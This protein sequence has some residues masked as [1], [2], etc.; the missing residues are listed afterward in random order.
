MSK[1]ILDVL[2]DQKK[3]E[4][5][6]V[7][8]TVQEVEN[9]LKNEGVRKVNTKDIK[10]LGN[11]FQEA[12]SNGSEAIDENKLASVGGGFSLKKAALAA[13]TIGTVVAGGYFADK[14]LNEGKGM[15]ALKSGAD[16]AKGQVN[17]WFSGLNKKPNLEMGSTEAFE[18]P[19]PEYN[20][21]GVHM[22]LND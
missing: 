20:D 14:Y 16:K 13:S 8:P 10:V 5:I 4:E 1:D 3:V 17:T 21:G 15:D 12:L 19:L 18:Q 22:G 7:L 2:S 11:V 9:K 6:A